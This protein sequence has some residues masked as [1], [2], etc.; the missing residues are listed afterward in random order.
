MTKSCLIN[1]KCIPCEGGVPPLSESSSK[2]LLGQLGGGWSINK[3]GHLFKE[4]TFQNFLDPLAFVNRIA[5]IAEEEAHH[6]DLSI[7]WGRVGIEIWT[8][9][10]SG[11]TESDF[12]LA[13]KIEDLHGSE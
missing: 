3:Q 4:Y 9:K 5:L 10:I 1:K 7:A 11:L 13:A 8:H 12:I 2:K 6:P